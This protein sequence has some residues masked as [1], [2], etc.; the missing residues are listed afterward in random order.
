M[1]NPDD[2][3]GSG[4][5]HH[6]QLEGRQLSD[7]LAL[8]QELT[9]QG[10][11]SESIGALFTTAFRV[12]FRSLP[13]DIAIAVM[14]EQNLDLYIVTRSGSEGLVSDRL[15]ET[16]RNI[17]QR[18]IPSFAT[19]DVVVKLERAELPA[20]EGEGDSLANELTAIFKQEN[21]TAGLLILCRSEAPFREDQGQI[22]EIFSTQVAMLLGNI[23]SR[24]KILNLADTDELTGIW[25]RRYFRRQVPLE[26]ERARIYNVPLSVIIFDVDDFKLINDSFGHTMGDVVLSEL[27][28]AVRERLRPPDIFVRFGGDEFAV[29]LPHTDLEGANAVAE[30]LL[31]R[32]AHLTI[33]T[34]DEASIR[35]A[36][37]IGVAEFQPSMDATANDLVRR[38]DEKM[39]DA[40]RLG[41]NRMSS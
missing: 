37:S 33:P 18:L 21:R 41:K 28:G 17:L 23:R 16:I 35:C 13:F 36:I 38:A 6:P 34:D 39:Y 40:K 11:Q 20:M 3:G 31:D 27:C 1:P 26:I 30:R 9:G 4:D 29:I 5:V 12:L 14:L 15:V 19:T 10:I 22:L 7:V 2:P 8:I 24:E 25:N 32:V